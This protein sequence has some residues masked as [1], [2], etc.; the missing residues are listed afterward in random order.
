MII[1]AFALVLD[2]V[3]LNGKLFFTLD[4]RPN[5]SLSSLGFSTRYLIKIFV[6]LHQPQWRNCFLS[7]TV[8]MA[9]N[10]ES[11]V[12]CYMFAD[13]RLY[14]FIRRVQ[15]F[16]GCLEWFCDWIDWARKKWLIVPVCDI[17]WCGWGSLAIASLLSY[18]MCVYIFPELTV[19]T[20]FH[21]N[22]VLCSFR[23]EFD[24][25]FSYG[26]DVNNF[27]IWELIVRCWRSRLFK[28]LWN[29]KFYTFYAR[30][31]STGDLYVFVDQGQHFHEMK[32]ICFRLCDEQ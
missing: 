32:R 11:K 17:K 1:Y 21:L 18:V 28:W 23:T 22:R 19:S 26:M 8:F 10:K 13:E 2:W 30:C 9:K 6:G 16:Y 15:D 12:P 3:C 25:N 14:C 24:E 20:F 27:L 31:I 7:D 29:G 4:Y 5:S